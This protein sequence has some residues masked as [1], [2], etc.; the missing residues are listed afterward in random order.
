MHR[1]IVAALAAVLVA[2]APAAAQKGGKGKKAAAAKV[3]VDVA[4]EQARL[5][6]TDADQAIAAAAALGAS[7]EPAAHDALA[8]ALA[9]GLAP[10]VAIA[11]LAALGKRP[12]K[13]D[14][15]LLRF[16]ARH[17]DVDVRAAALVPTADATILIGGLRDEHPKVRAAAARAIAE[18][19]HRAAAEPLLALLAKGD[20]PAA[21]ALAAIADVELA[22]VIGEQ[23][24]QVPDALL[25][26]ALGGILLR[27]DFGPDTAR[28]EVVRALGKVAGAEATT[29]L[30]DY[31]E[32]TPENPPR[33]SRRE[34]EAMVEARLGGD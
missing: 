9:T 32:A 30:A 3:K 6:G 21:A 2:A 1:R 20:E 17:R 14:A 23:L 7:P 26:A 19:K 29:A 25:A 27:K 5:A 11:A 13:G 10:E 22:R 34:A 24:G 12:A 15:A 4:A 16:Y 28:V 18:G 33:A 31:V 8:D